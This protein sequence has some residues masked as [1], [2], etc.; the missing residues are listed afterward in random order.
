V[1]TEH[2]LPIAP[3]MDYEHVNRQ[4]GARERSETLPLNQSRRVRRENYGIY[5]ARKECPELNRESH[6]VARCAV[7]RLMLAAGLAGVIRGQV[8]RTTIPDRLLRE[9]G[10]WSAGDAAPAAPN[11]LVVADIHPRI[12]LA[13]VGAR[14]LSFI[15][16]GAAHP[17]SFRRLSARPPRRDFCR[18]RDSPSQQPAVGLEPGGGVLDAGPCRRPALEPFRADGLVTDLADPV[19]PYS[20]AGGGGGDLV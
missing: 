15:D 1:L 5:G 17:A 2:A 20:E 11:T 3:S 9:P 16:P 12:H 13:R 6:P 4:P 7:Q 10:T 19:A 14:D 18:E 8:K